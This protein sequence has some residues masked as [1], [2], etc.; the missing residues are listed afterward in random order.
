MDVAILYAFPGSSFFQWG[1]TSGVLSTSYIPLNDYVFC[2]KATPAREAGSRAMERCRIRAYFLGRCSNKVMSSFG[3]D[4]FP[5]VPTAWL[6]SRRKYLRIVSHYEVVRSVSS[7]LCKI[8]FIDLF[9]P[10]GYKCH[11]LSCSCF[12]GIQVLSFPGPYWN[13][14]SPKL[15][16]KIPRQRPIRQDGNKKPFC[17]F[18]L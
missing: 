16:V 5:G 10:A 17:S 9:P 2:D 4:C 8:H 7:S 15:N 12:H 6:Y 14:G 13:G 18:Q 11:H 1:Q 3:S